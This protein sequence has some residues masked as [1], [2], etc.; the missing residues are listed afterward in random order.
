MKR[1]RDIELELMA[2][3][4]NSALAE[5]AFYKE[6]AEGS[7]SRAE[8]DAVCAEKEAAVNQLKAERVLHETEV[9]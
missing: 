8:Y 9:A 6:K 2:M 3:K 7:V 5:A 1:Q 4:L